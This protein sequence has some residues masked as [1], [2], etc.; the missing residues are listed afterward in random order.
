MQRCNDHLQVNRNIPVACLHGTG[1]ALRELSRSAEKRAAL[2][3]LARAFRENVGDAVSDLLVAGIAETG[4][5]RYI[6]TCIFEQ[7]G[8]PP[9]RIKV[10]LRRT[11][12]NPETVEE[13]MGTA[14]QIW[15]E[16]G[17]TEGKADT[18]L[19]QARR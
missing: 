6:L 18:S 10:A 1:I 13:V 16:Q 14:A 8:L 3:A 5:G 7:V 17:R 4:F 2:L 19:R 15:M 12:T 9:E 11:G